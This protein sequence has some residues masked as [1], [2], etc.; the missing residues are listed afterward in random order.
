VLVAELNELLD[1]P[2]S[3]WRGPRDDQAPRRLSQSELARVLSTFGIK[4]K[5]IWPLRRSAKAKSSKGY[6]RKQFEAAWASYCD[7]TAAQ[8]SNLRYLRGA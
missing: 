2:W 5:W 7:G 6:Y 1:A 4:S 3:E 8:P